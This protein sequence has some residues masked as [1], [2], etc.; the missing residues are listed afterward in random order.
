MRDSKC[1]RHS[2]YWLL[3]CGGDGRCVVAALLQRRRG[4]DI[5]SSRL[6][7]EEDGIEE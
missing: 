7:V 4:E 6:G 3:I 5:R 2:D 1:L